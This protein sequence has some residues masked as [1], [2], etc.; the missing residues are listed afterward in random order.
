M[1]DLNEA[2]SAIKSKE[3][4]ITVLNYYGVYLDKNNKTCCPF[5]NEKT[6]SFSVSDEGFYKCFG[7]DCTNG[8][9]DVFNF[10]MA[11]ENCDFISALIKAYEILGMP[12]DIEIKGKIDKRT[13]LKNYIKKNDYYNIDGH[14]I[15]NIFIYDVDELI[16]ENIEN[17]DNYELIR[18]INETKKLVAKLTESGQIEVKM[19][20]FD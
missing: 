2:T 9:G 6:P 3:N 16:T 13:K 15:E 14:Y 5:H 17:L 4:L 7:K 20:L 8:K 18:R 11:K 19:V 1:I 10:I 12:L